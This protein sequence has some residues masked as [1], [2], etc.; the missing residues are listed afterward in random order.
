MT[1]PHHNSSRH[2]RPIMAAILCVLFAALCFAGKVKTF[3]NPE[4]N[5]GSYR[6]YRWAPTKVLR[7]TGIVE[8]D[9][10][11]SPLIK[12]AVNH[13]LAGRGFREVSEGGDLEVVTCALDT[14]VPQ[15]EAFIFPVK[16]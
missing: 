5:L 2:S 3:A 4:S 16:S 15:L 6:T 13:E 10:E 14:H 1:S 9:P 7:K 8:D 11:L 12:A